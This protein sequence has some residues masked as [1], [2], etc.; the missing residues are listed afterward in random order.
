MGTC[1]CGFTTDE[2]KNCN[3][4]HKVVQ[5]VRDKIAQ[6]IESIPLETGEPN[7]QLNALGMRML[8]ADIARGKK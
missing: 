5:A 4:T 2:E 7:A 6:D 8:A 1:K 3:G